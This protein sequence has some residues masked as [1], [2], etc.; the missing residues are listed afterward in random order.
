MVV[1][2]CI[3]SLFPG[4]R[5]RSAVLALS[6]APWSLCVCSFGPSLLLSFDGSQHYYGLC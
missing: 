6:Q 1:A 2:S 3:A 5:V 4:G